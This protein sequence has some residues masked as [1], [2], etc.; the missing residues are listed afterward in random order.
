M[1]DSEVKKA[2]EAIG[3]VEHHDFNVRKGVAVMVGKRAEKVKESFKQLKA[4][5]VNALVQEFDA[6]PW[7]AII[8]YSKDRKQLARPH[9]EFLE[10]QALATSLDGKTGTWR[11]HHESR[12][13]KTGTRIMIIDNRQGSFDVGGQKWI[14]FCDDHGNYCEHE[15]LKLASRHY[16]HP[17]GWC[18]DCEEMMV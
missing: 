7:I 16:A 5:D 8:R 4:F 15:T 17:E 13:R 2:L 1:A 12:N 6:D 18:G 3:F 14:T 10:L 9:G 11:I